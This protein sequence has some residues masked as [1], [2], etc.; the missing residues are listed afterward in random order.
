ML[1]AV[2]ASVESRNAVMICNTVAPAS[3]R[4]STRAPS[5]SAAVIAIACPDPLL[6]WRRLAAKHGP[7]S[8]PTSA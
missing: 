4:G 3:A 8:R 7:Q 5:T 2:R 6:R 1:T